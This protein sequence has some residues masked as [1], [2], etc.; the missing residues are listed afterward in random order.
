MSVSS[1]CKVS[2]IS[3]VEILHLIYLLSSIWGLVNA[4]KDWQKIYTS[5]FVWKWF[6]NIKISQSKKV[7]TDA[8]AY[9]QKYFNRLVVSSFWSIV[10]MDVKMSHQNIKCLSR[11]DLLLLK[12]FFSFTIV[13]GTTCFWKYQHWSSWRQLGWHKS[14]F[15]NFKF[16]HKSKFHIST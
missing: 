3:G 5:D 9:C 10:A 15:S 13:N 16:G 6:K 7:S 11:F 4:G 14:E 2:G 1:V 12:P 8:F